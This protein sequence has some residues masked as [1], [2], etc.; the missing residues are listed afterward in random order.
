MKIS[1][2]SDLNHPLFYVAGPI[3]GGGSWQERAYELFAKEEPDCIVATPCRYALDH[4][5]R[6]WTHPHAVPDAF[7]RQTDWE[8]EY[9]NEAVYGAR[10]CLMFWLPVE[11]VTDP[12]PREDGPY[13]Q[14]SYGELGYWRALIEG[15]FD[16]SQLAIVIG[17]EPG[18]HGLRKLQRDL[19]RAVDGTFVI[20]PT[21]EA[22]VKAA[23]DKARM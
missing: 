3:R 15:S 9:M 6:V 12:R 22:T 17:A 18:F 11:S 1:P 20:H 10:G 8:D 5:V 14:D 2:A 4:S 16:P 19:D 21:L 7:E 13:A 23:V